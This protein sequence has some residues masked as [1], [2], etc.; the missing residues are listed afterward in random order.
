MMPYDLLGTRRD[1]KMQR[2]WRAVVW[3]CPLCGWWFDPAW[4]H[5]S[6]MC[7]ACAGCWPHPYILKVTGGA[8]AGDCTRCGVHTEQGVTTDEPLTVYDIL[9]EDPLF[10]RAC[11]KVASEDMNAFYTERWDGVRK[12]REWCEQGV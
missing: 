4:R 8:L 6:R 5:S 7:S 2:A 1:V 3:R 9:L 12:L 10:C 11:Q